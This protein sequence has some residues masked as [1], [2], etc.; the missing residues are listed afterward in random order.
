GS[1]DRETEGGACDKAEDQPLPGG[2]ERH[3]PC[4]SPALTGRNHE[5]KSD[6]QNRGGWD[7]RLHTEPG[8]Q[9]QRKGRTGV[10]DEPGGADS[11][12][13]LGASIYLRPVPFDQ[14][15]VLALNKV[16]AK[17]APAS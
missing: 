14:A 12:P 3:L 2:D 8:A 7:S 1:G 9:A 6:I 17:T 5:H 10:S 4:R 16:P 11:R 15:D 13:V